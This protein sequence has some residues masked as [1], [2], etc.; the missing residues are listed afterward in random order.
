MLKKF[1]SM[2]YTYSIYLLNG[3]QIKLLVQKSFVLMKLTD[4]P[5]HTGMFIL[6]ICRL[7]TNDCFISM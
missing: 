6:M 1:Y 3:L 2:F 5:L 7:D 4:P